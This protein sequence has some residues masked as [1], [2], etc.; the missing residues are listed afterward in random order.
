MG[1]LSPEREVSLVTGRSVLDAAKK[2]GLNAVGVDV[3]RDIAVRLKQ[4]KF[5]L[6][7][8]ALHGNFGEDGT[9][10][11]LLEYA[12][13][14][15]TGAGVLGSALAYDKV[16]SKEVFA[17][18][19]IPSAEYQVLHSNGGPARRILDLPVVVK[20][21]NQ[22]SSLGISVVKEESQ[23]QSALDDAFKYGDEVVAERFIEGKLLAIGMN[24][25]SP[26]P[27]VHI[28]P[29]S[30]FYDYEAKYTKGKTLYHCPAALTQEETR[31]CQDTALRVYHALKGRGLPR[32]DVILD[33]AGVPYVLEMNTI[34]GLTPTSLLPM[35]ARE[36]GIE[37]EDLVVTIL[38]TA[39]L[40]NP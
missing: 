22:G 6:A 13:I 9:V 17:M 37:F 19:G 33:P 26:L 40:D 15:Y 8:I 31:T 23:W 21:S 3:D 39:Q 1:G 28:E 16:K 14:P 34:P 18:H 24:G 20:P 10:Q 25:T 27:V 7:F 11:G 32:V 5:D 35:A 30:G 29:K 2:K 36:A 12:G 4:E 38:N